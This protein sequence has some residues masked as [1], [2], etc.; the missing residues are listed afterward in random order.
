MNIKNLLKLWAYTS[1]LLVVLLC[2]FLSITG[3]YAQAA[4][5]EA[6]TI[7]TMPQGKEMP[8]HT[9]KLLVKF[10]DNQPKERIDKIL[11]ETN[12]TSKGKISPIGVHIV[13][14][15]A[16]VNEKAYVNVFK[17]YSEVEF[18]EIDM[19]VSPDFMTPN[20][21]WY[22]KQWHLSKISAPYAWS[23]TKGS[24]TVIVAILDTGVDSTHPDLT[25]KII[26][27]WNFYNNNGDTMDLL[28]HGTAVAGTVAA[29]TNNFIGVAS[30]AWDCMIMPI[31]I[32]DAQGYATY[33]AAANGLIWSADRG[34]RVA[35]ISYRMSESSTVANAA[36]YFQEKGGVVTISAGN[37]ST[38]ISNSDNP[39]VLTVSAT[40]DSDAPANFSNSG[41]IIDVSAPGVSI[42]TTTIPKDG[43]YYNSVSG[44]SFS[45]PIVAGI[46]A[47]VI[48]ANPTLTGFQVQEIIK[49]SA[50]DLGTAGWDPVYGWGRGNTKK[51]VELA[52]G[53]TGDVDAIPPSVGFTKPDNGSVVSG[54]LNIQVSATDNIK[55]NSVKLFINGVLHGVSSVSPYNFE[56]DTTK[57]ANGSYTLQA[58]ATDGA[59]NSSTAT[60][61]V[62]VNNVQDTIPPTISITSPK[63]GAVVK[64]TV[65]VTVSASDNIKVTKVE[66]YINGVLTDTSFTAPFNLKWN[67][68]SFAKGTHT[69]QAKAYDASGNVGFSQIVKVVK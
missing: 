64:N 50:D 47:L 6:P 49:K 58:V 68:R 14:L 16:N 17:N 31:R 18:A 3:S 42:F 35:N 25:N 27:G 30:L 65:S 55:V 57:V 20:D 46:A 9:G 24:N 26:P 63:D 37:Q 19:I 7:W 53:T 59:E 43:Y 32:G 12:S 23:Y 11:A 4:Q 33:S 8:A 69:L 36:K 51:A 28:G 2:I 45:A 61:S 5:Q 34:A 40:N 10:K 62:V 60:I 21:P 22:A 48:S 39:Y 41:N 56:W 66:L 44:T 67:T 38:F 1:G 29:Y 13:E 52:L 54:L 15:P